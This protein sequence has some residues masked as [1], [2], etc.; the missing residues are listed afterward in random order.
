MLT[1]F[2]HLTY[3]TNIHTGESWQEHF[4]EIKKNFP[5][6][7]SE[8]SPD[9]PMG[10]GLRLSNVASI[11]LIEDTNLQV[12]KQWLYENQAYVFTMNGFPYGSFHDTRVKD[13]VHVPDWT[14]N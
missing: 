2:G 11:D 6:I 12:F 7:K 3:C 10:I 9:K 8:L 4:S 1:G 13:Q 14:T 5:G